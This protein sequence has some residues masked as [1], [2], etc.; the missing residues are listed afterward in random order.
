MATLCLQEEEMFPEK[1]E[2]F[3]ILNDKRV[4]GFKEKDSVQNTWEKV[5]ASLD[6]T[7]NGNFIRA[8]SNWEYF[9]GSCSKKIGALFCVRN[10]Y[11]ILASQFNLDFGRL[12]VQNSSSQ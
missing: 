1:M 11:K 12:T 6:F 9:E 2:G 7:E 5:A 10:S 4:T 8:T 3:P